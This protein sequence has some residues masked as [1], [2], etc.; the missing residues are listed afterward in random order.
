MNTT[1]Q[2]TATH[3]E[4]V[5]VLHPDQVELLRHLL[6]TVEDWL[7]H[8]SDEALDDL[9]GFLT[10]LGWVSHDAP[11]RLTANLISEL[12]DQAV[13]L[14]TALQRTEPRHDDRDQPVRV[15]VDHG[16]TSA[17]GQRPGQVWLVKLRRGNHAVII[18]TGLA[19]PCADHLAS[20]IN[21]FLGSPDTQA[22]HTENAD[23]QG[24]DAH[25]TAQHRRVSA[26]DRAGTQTGRPA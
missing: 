3:P 6:G 18:T 7:L 1:T 9:G 13:A 2:N 10:G 14:R 20:K 8:C 24:A 19:R 15:E 16:S 12:G 26:S 22:R 5:V 17:R 11:E 21:T 25:V 4:P 23:A